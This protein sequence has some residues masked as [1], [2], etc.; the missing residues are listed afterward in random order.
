MPQ[1]PAPRSG[2]RAPKWGIWW[3]RV[4]L[5]GIAPLAFLV[6]LEAALRIAGYGNPSTLFI[7][8]D[9]PGFLRTNPAF[10]HT[11]F[12]PQ[13]DITP[14][15][16][17]LSRHKEPGHIRIFVLGES[18][19]RGI[20]EPGF[21]FAALMRAQ[22]R[23][24]YPG[25][26]FDVYNLGI[27][28]I[29]S[30][31]VY[32]IAKEVAELEPDLFV[33]YMGNNEVVGPFGPGSVNRSTQFPLPLIRASIWTAQTRIGQLAARILRG[34]SG[35]A[36]Q[37]TQWHG[38]T[39][40]IDKT[41][42]GDEPRLEKVYSD[43]QANLRAILEIAREHGIKTVLSTVVCNLRD[44]APFSSLHSSNLTADQLA[45]WTAAYNDGSDSLELGDASRA[46][47][48]LGEAVH[49]DPEFA[50]EHFL[51]GRA[52]EAIGQT[53]GAR[54]EYLQAL[55]WDALRF[56]PDPRINDV[57]RAVGSGPSGATRLLDAAL[58]LGSDAQ[59]HGPALGRELLWEHVHF[60]L[61]GDA[62]MSLMLAKEVSA[63]LF[64]DA[65]APAPWLDDPACTAALGYTPQGRAQMLSAMQAI[66]SR[67]PFTNQLTFAEDQLR[68]AK[69]L[70][71]SA[72]DAKAQTSGSESLISG[73]LRRDPSNA[74]LWL[75]L[76]E[77]Q[78]AAGNPQGAVDSIDKAV[79]LTPLSADLLVRRSH[80]LAAAKRFG[81]ATADILRAIDQAPDHLPAYSELVD[82]L[83]KA[84][85]FEAGRAIFIHALERTPSSDYLRL[86]WADL[87]FFHGDKLEAELECRTVLAR[88]PGSAEALGRLVSLFAAENRKDDAFKLMTEARRTQPG[89]FANDMALARAYQERHLDSDVAECLDLAAQSG[90]VEPE[91]HVFLGRRL[92]AMNQTR[93]A[94]VE[95]ARA[96][97][98][99]LIEGNQE[100]ADALAAV[101]S[102][103]APGR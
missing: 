27:V 48:S 50:N 54:G 74:Y 75:R 94:M 89:N 66:L 17:R 41:V 15:N 25:R 67:P 79:A 45:R 80:A 32:Q 33:I 87:L 26:E 60:N 61:E 73:A 98:G 99:A 53:R 71:R 14:L 83:R 49:I 9:K 90:P 1:P 37:E 28:A 46:L 24:A 10:T 51:L 47:V 2:E 59:S 22:L 72:A 91:V 34:I 56:R 68:Y 95:F 100:M 101:I 39:T 6:S 40:F 55:H 96:R 88:D 70:D 57:I 52:N 13:F 38:M 65:P 86:Q 20:A 21:G 16:F 12:P 5:V 23:A 84:G 11:Y 4:L 63:T 58:L 36:A 62:R 102:Q 19:A 18:A 3:K 8:D 30:H 42:R 93:D 69:D 29:N 43:F 92:K 35:R 81:E 76:S 85:D 82:I 103:M 64:G 44:C 7:P 31:A 97:R 78:L 77:V